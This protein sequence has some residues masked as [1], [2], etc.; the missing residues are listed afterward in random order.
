MEGTGKK[1]D[2]LLHAYVC[3]VDGWVYT[4]ACTA[5]GLFNWIERSAQSLVV[6]VRPAHASFTMLLATHS[7]RPQCL[8]HRARE[9]PP[10]ICTHQRRGLATP[11]RPCRAAAIHAWIGSPC[12]AM[13][14]CTHAHIASFTVVRTRGKTYVHAHQFLYF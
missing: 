10:C 7:R 6:V 13:H 2:I 14:A 8:F 4:Y 12:H 11:I 1:T 5:V 3:T 9:S